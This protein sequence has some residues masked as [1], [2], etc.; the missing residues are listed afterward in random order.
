MKLFRE[1]LYLH[2]EHL[3]LQNIVSIHSSHLLLIFFYCCDFLEEECKMEVCQ[4]FTNRGNS[5]DA[6]SSY[7]NRQV[8]DQQS[9][10]D[11][12][13]YAEWIELK[14]IRKSGTVIQ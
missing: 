10:N 7:V 9:C 4:D 2:H 1:N 13:C 12:R 14:L 5:R 6:F 11:T 3:V 8:V